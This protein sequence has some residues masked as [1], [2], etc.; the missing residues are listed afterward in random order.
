MRAAI[1]VLT[2]LVGLAIATAVGAMAWRAHEDHGLRI[3]AFSVSPDLAQKGLTGQVVAGQLLDKLAALQAKTVTGR[4]GPPPTPTTGAAT[5]RSRF[6][7][8]ASRS[9]S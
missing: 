2:V 3:E 9:A 4:A 8:R 7:R 6:P 5:S 1:Q